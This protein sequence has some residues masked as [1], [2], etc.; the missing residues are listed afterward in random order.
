MQ[1]LGHLIDQC[2]AGEQKSQ[3]ALYDY[4][5]GRLMGICIRYHLNKEEANDVFHDAIIRIFKNLEKAREVKDFNAWASRVAINVAIDA[6]KKRRSST[7]LSLEEGGVW[8]FSS[9]ELDAISEM[10]ASE[11]IALLHKLPESQ[12][13]TFNMFIDGYSHKEIGERLAIA[14]SSSRT[15]LTRAKKKMTRLISRREES[16]K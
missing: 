12:M 11:I 9:E 16:G 2:I 10:S 7:T 5:K 4:L 3:R 13:I 8:Q 15:L 14:E 6:Y 1:D